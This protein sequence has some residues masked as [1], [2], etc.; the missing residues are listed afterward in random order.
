MPMVGKESEM[1]PYS[2]V[3]E[4]PHGVGD[5]TQF[6]LLEDGSLFVEIDEQ[7]QG[8]TESGFGVKCSITLPPPVARAMISE[9]HL[10][11]REIPPAPDTDP[12]A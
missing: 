6:T 7:W 2:F 11:L 8:D 12:P 5:E 3:W 4:D 9:L 10:A 1:R